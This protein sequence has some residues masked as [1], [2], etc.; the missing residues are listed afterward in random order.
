MA[1]NDATLSSDVFTTVRSVIVNAVPKITYTDK[2]AASKTKTASVLAQYNDKTPSAP[3]IVILP[4]DVSEDSWRF[5]GTEGK[6]FINVMLECY[7]TTTL[8]VDQLADTIKA[9]I[10]TACENQT[11]S[12]M[13]LVGISENY[14]FVNPGDMK[15]HLKTLTFT[16]D[17]E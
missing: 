4:S 7:Y 6:K 17:R 5:G 16:F 12:G 13:E 14:A 11:I 1:I 2:S 10:K 3:Q 15:F 9:A 8:G